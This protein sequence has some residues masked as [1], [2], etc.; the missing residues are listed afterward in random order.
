VP[1]ITGL[2]RRRRAVNHVLPAWDLVTGQMAATGL[3]AAERHRRLTGAGQ[4][5]MLALE[6]MALA[7]MGHLGFIAEAELGERARA[8]RQLPVRRIRQGFRHR[9]RR[10]RDGPSA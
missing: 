7:V 10:A 8:A 4:H 9:R 3:L 2:G 1:L 5:V 6:D